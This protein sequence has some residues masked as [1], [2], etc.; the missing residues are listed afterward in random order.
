MI[1]WPKQDQHVCLWYRA[2]LR[3]VTPHD[4]RGIVQIAA[5]GPGP[6]NVLVKIHN[7]QRFV[8]PRGNLQ[9]R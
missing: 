5:H 6:R 1:Y 8:V 3:G 4:C 9:E 7:G 2:S